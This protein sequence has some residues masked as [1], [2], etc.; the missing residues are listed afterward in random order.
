MSRRCCRAPTS[1]SDGY[2]I[3]VEGACVP[4]P[5][6]ERRRPAAVQGRPAAVRPARRNVAGGEEARDRIRD[7]TLSRR[8]H[9]PHDRSTTT[10]RPFHPL[11]LSSATTVSSRIGAKARRDNRGEA[12]RTSA[13]YFRCRAACRCRSVRRSGRRTGWWSST[14]WS[15]FLGKPINIQPKFFPVN[16]DLAA[17]WIHR[18]ARN[19]ATPQALALDRRGRPRDLGTGAQHRG[20][21]RRWRRSPR[22]CGLSRRQLRAR[23][24]ALKSRQRY[25]ALTQEAIARGVPRRADLRR[26]RTNCS[27]DRTGSTSSPANWQNSVFSLG[28]TS[29]RPNWASGD[30]RGCLTAEPGRERRPDAHRGCS[31]ERAAAFHCTSHYTGSTQAMTTGLHLRARLR[32]GGDRRRQYTGSADPRQARRQS[33]HAGNRGRHPG[34]RQGLSQSP[35]HGRLRSSASSCSSIIWRALGARTA[36]GFALGAILSG[37]TGYIGMNVSVRSNVRTAGSRA[38]RV[39]TEA[40]A[41]ALPRRRDHRHAGRRA[42]RYWAWRASTA[43]LTGSAHWAPNQMGRRPAQDRSSRWWASRSAAR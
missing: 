13:K 43:F 17:Y 41:V 23:V 36:G 8:C 3:T 24:K 2:G 12:D 35:V 33:A 30:R 38:H 32:G 16:G 34:R 29:Y 31:C 28:R 15:Q 42:R 1:A 14:R 10:S 39:S 26:R 40:L 18:G 9:E 25:A 4:A 19:W 21:R 27:G 22:E 20:C 6:D 7:L 11:D 5:A 37:L